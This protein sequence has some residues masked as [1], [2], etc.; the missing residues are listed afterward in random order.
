MARKVSQ[1]L[2]IMIHKILPKLYMSKSFH[3]MAEAAISAF[4]AAIGVSI[5]LAVVTFALRRLHNKVYLAT[6]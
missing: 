3:S 4:G 1:F 6:I 5:A 2:K